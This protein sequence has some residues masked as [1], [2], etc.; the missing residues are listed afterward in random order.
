MNPTTTHCITTTAAT[1]I[2]RRFLFTSACSVLCT[3]NIKPSPVLHSSIRSVSSTNFVF[4]AKF[5]SRAAHKRLYTFNPI[6][7]SR[8]PRPGYHGTIL[9]TATL[10]SLAIP[11]YPLVESSEHAFGEKK[12]LEES[13]DIT[14]EQHLFEASRRETQERRQSYTENVSLP[15]RSCRKLIVFFCEWIYEPIATTLRFLHLIVIFVPVLVTIPAILG[16]VRVPEKSDERRSTL[17]WYLFLVNSMERAGPTF[18]KV[19]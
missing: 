4:A 1:I 3:P 9:L 15:K 16:R 13:G 10:A 8:I 5:S 7:H 6:K 14:F 19:E 17:W 18:I 12:G 2:A 11:A